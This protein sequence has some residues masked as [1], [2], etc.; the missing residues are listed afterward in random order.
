MNQRVVDAV[1]GRDNQGGTTKPRPSSLRRCRGFLR[2]PGGTMIDQLESLEGRARSELGSAG[3]IDDLEAWR[4]RYLGRAGE[5]TLALRGIGQAPP[6]QRPQLG[7]R[8][9]VLRGAL[10]AAL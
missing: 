3:S 8:L 6:E 4:L 9:N 7:Q 2:C 10:D 5:L 1:P